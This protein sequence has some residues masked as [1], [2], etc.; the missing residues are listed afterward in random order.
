[1]SNNLYGKLT[2]A[3]AFF[4]L[5]NIYAGTVIYS[6]LGAG[7]AYEGDATWDIN[8]PGSVNGFQ[9][10]ADPFT[11][12]S[13][14]S[15]TQ[16]DAALDYYDG[17]NSVTLSLNADSGGLPGAVLESWVI[18]GL[19]AAATTSTLVQTVTPVSSLLLNAGTQYWIVVTAAGSTDAGW[20]ENSLGLFGNYA[21]ES[22][23]G[24]GW[25]FNSGQ[26]LAA[27]DVQ[28]TIPGSS[29][30]EPATFAF[31]AAGLLALGLFK[32]RG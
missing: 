23:Q 31:A 18:T 28:G 1:L 12:G 19:P 7:N 16:I 5:T 20:N 13:S 3:A 25:A 30:P 29:V 2:L 11:P 32:Q 10:I 22:S 17:T 24:G 27:F 8:G 15:L 26:R 21:H 6:T 9:A 14:Y 4:T